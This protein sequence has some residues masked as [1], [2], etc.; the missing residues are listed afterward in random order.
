MPTVSIRTGLLLAIASLAALVAISSVTALFIMRSITGQQEIVTER[1]FPAAITATELE[2]ETG[3]ILQFMDR[4]DRAPT[5]QA[6]EELASEFATAMAE[7]KNTTQRLHSQTGSTALTDQLDGLLVDLEAAITGYVDISRQRAQLVASQSDAVALISDESSNLNGVTDSLV[8]NARAT[9]TNRLSRMYDTVEDPYMIDDT[10]DTLDNILD[11][12][13][14]Y[15]T[16]MSDLRNNALLL[17]QLSLKLLAANDIETLDAF[18]SKILFTIETIDREVSSIDDPERQ[19]QAKAF[20]DKMLTVLGS[21]AQQSLYDSIVES[22]ANRDRATITRAELDDLFAQFENTVAEIVSIS[23]AQIEKSVSKAAQQVSVGNM[24][25]IAIAI[26]A[27]LLSGAIGY[28]Y[29]SKHI[30]QR[31]SQLSNMTK[32]MASGNIDM[33]LPRAPDDE[34]GQMVTALGI[35]QKGE[36]ERREQKEREQTRL[37]ET[38]DFVSTLSEALRNLS[39]GDLR[40]RIDQDVG[41]EFSSIC[42][43]YNQ[44]VNRLNEILTDV[45]GTSETISSGMQSLY[46]AS[47]QLAKRTEQQASAVTQT[48]TTLA[49]IK[50]EV[51]GTASGARDAWELSQNAQKKAEIGRDVVAQSTNAMER[52]K[53]STDEISSF[54]GLIDDIAFQTNLLALNAGVEAA[55]AGQAGSGFAVVAAEVRG[56]AQRA[57]TAAQDI[58]TRINTS[59]TDVQNGEN[60]ANE[61]RHALSEIEDMVKE[62]NT[63]IMDISTTAQSQVNSIREINTAMNEIENVTQ[64]N[65]AMVEETNASTVALQSDVSSMLDS[66]SVFKLD[67]PQEKSA[68]QEPKFTRSSNSLELFSAMANDAD[69]PAMRTMTG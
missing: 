16:R 54:I 38:S 52:I 51:E 7:T 45:V 27:I 4:L 68:S 39:M 2:A 65:A 1:A 11:I 33:T 19:A 14:P 9:V 55:R 15:S 35:F 37:K 10:Y 49:Q 69:I 3:R 53:K 50:N 44:S 41:A 25:L 22:L 43:N 58:K 57:S 5:V 66:A 23:A 61:T 28:G 18:Q 12:D 30:L 32:E 20:L 59:V 24:T 31:L 6:V 62:L 13:Q 40:F 21:D 42:V 29:V 63:A 46:N 64:H 36:I 17:Q 8:A 34:L 26:T 48:T 60:L 67:D 56:L 47:I